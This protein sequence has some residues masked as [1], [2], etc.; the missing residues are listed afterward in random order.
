[1]AV[2]VCVPNFF[3]LVGFVGAVS[4]CALGFTFPALIEIFVYYKEPGYGK[5]KWRLVKNV[6]IIIISIILCVSGTIISIQ[7]IWNAEA[8]IAH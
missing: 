4:L 5:Y 2:A 6:I 3:P 7:M 8:G 1:M